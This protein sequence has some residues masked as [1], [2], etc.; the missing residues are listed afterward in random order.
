[1]ML[2]NHVPGACPDFDC[3][4]WLL[5]LG[6]V[7]GGCPSCHEHGGLYVEYKLEYT[8]DTPA[9]GTLVAPCGGCG[10][11]SVS[12][13][14]RDAGL[15]AACDR[16]GCLSAGRARR[17]SYLTCSLCGVSNRAEVTRT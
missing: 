3:E 14:K 7:S 2:D 6:N 13:V 12:L 15:F 5:R 16:D 1:M 9:A 8:E 4:H 17:W 10:S 11:D